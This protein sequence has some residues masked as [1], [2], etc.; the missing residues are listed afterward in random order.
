MR[1]TLV[2]F[3][4]YLLFSAVY[5]WPA[6]C[7]DPTVLPT[8]HFDLYPAL[9][10][11]QTA[12]SVVPRLF[13]SFSAWPYGESLA[14]IDSY[15][16]L[17]LGWLN[18]NFF[19]S[20][21]VADLL[22]W[23]GPALNALA[24]E[25]CAH[26]AFGIPRPQSWLAGLTFGFSGITAVALLEGHVYHLLNPWLP[27]LLGSL[28]LGSGPQ[29]RW[30]HG[31]LGGLAW[32][33][34][35]FTTAYFGVC[36]AF[37]TVAL[38]LRA[39]RASL[40]LVP[41]LLLTVLPATA[42]YLWLFSLGGNWKDNAPTTGVLQSGTSTLS[43]LLHASPSVD[44]GGHSIAAPLHFM[45]F[46]LWFLAPF[47]LKKEWKG[48]WILALGML[49]A[50][51]G[52]YF[53]AVP[54]GAGVAS[55]LAY[56]ALWMPSL[57]FFR[58][59]IRLLWVFSLVSGILASRVLAERTQGRF[60][61]GLALL[62]VLLSS[63]MP[64]RLTQGIATVPSAYASAPE[65]RAVLD[66]YG[67]SLDASSGELEMRARALG[68][69]Y[70]SVHRR[71]IAEVCIG[72]GIQ[73]PREKLSRF[74]MRGLGQNPEGTIHALEAVGIGAI[75]LHLDTLR[76]ADA[77]VLETGLS[78]VLGTPAESQDGGE[79]LLLFGL[80]ATEEGNFRKGMEGI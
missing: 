62:D 59:P 3:A 57:A 41:G 53:R 38:L 37:L 28:W 77:L 74:L 56:L 12:P 45:S 35:Q 34:G 75:A 40:K 33:L 73:S 48:L 6:V 63:G 20:V 43:G 13:H 70:Q 71:P 14:R 52:A 49:L 19:S 21:Q 55:P 4:S 22:I 29:G 47:L 67:E 64:G 31:L 66:I 54:G 7:L 51:F 76:P 39:P 69:Y 80:T 9:W 60:W 5:T 78:G 65:G 32:V 23:L 8:R 25:L 61:M 46:W 79:H 58:F 24:A 18:Q 36:G 11:I 68:C 44:L 50:S 16:L 27:L 1:G 72:T 2:V 10:L 17:L 42:Y 26:R 15:L 30:Y